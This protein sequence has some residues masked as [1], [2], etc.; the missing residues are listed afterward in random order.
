MHRA[1]SGCAKAYCV[2]SAA[3]QITH[4]KCPHSLEK[5]N[6][7]PCGLHGVWKILDSWVH[8]IHAVCW[9]IFVDVSTYTWPIKRNCEA[10]T[11]I[12]TWY[13]I[14]VMTYSIPC[15]SKILCICRF[16]P[17]YWYNDNSSRHV[18]LGNGNCGWVAVICCY[19]MAGEPW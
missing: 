16:G 18:P 15:A 1:P 8:L 19:F 11:Q 12:W 3:N 7:G 4:G 10:L 6:T 17:N 14:Y 9:G 5:S 13:I 2:P